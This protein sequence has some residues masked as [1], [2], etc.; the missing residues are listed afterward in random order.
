MCWWRTHRESVGSTPQYV[1][2]GPAGVLAVPDV[3]EEGEVPAS[4]WV[5][6][7]NQ[8]G[9]GC[10][11]QSRPASHGLIPDEIRMSSRSGDKKC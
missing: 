1:S 9:T 6:Y 5:S 8:S 11:I 4:G 10:E 7:L 3:P 2:S